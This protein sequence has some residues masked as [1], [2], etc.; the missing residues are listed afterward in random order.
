MRLGHFVLWTMQSGQLHHQ[1]SHSHHCLLLLLF[2]I[3]VVV[4]VVVFERLVTVLVGWWPET[5]WSTPVSS[6]I[7]THTTSPHNTVNNRDG[8]P[9]TV[10]NGISVNQ[11]WIW[12]SIEV[13]T[14]RS[15]MQNDNYRGKYRWRW[16]GKFCRWR[17]IRWGLRGGFNTT[18]IHISL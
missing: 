18:S 7:I 4:V 12:V 2:V 6:I 3:S 5:D 13:M 9:W 8:K 11:P 10:G 14:Y 17:V 1:C 16:G 15:S